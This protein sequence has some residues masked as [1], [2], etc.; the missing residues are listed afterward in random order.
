MLLVS[1]YGLE[2]QGVAGITTIVCAPASE[3]TSNSSTLTS[4][5]AA[6]AFVSFFMA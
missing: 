4:R 5:L 6:C 1:A 2:C 3:S